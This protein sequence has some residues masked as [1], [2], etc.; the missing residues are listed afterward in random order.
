MYKK[1]FGGSGCNNST[2]TKHLLTAIHYNPYGNYCNAFY[3]IQFYLSSRDI[4]KNGVVLQ[5]IFVS[6]NG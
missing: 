4:R 3:H 1:G 5:A 2:S 6:L